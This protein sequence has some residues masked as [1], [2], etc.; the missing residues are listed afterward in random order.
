MNAGPGPGEGTRFP[1]RAGRAQGT[2]I[3]EDPARN[4]AAGSTG[5]RPIDGAD[6]AHCAPHL[7]REARTTREPGNAD[8]APAWA[9][10]DHL[11]GRPL[12][13]QWVNPPSENP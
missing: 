5:P 10:T 3:G 6:T 13:A 11:V 1:P 8:V 2:V 12:L 4:G 7:F 9:T